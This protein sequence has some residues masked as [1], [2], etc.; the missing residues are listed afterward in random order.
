MPKYSR[1]FRFGRGRKRMRGRGIFDFLA[2]VND[3]LK[4]SKIISSVAGMIPSGL[5][6]G[7]SLGAG[8][9]GYGRRRRRLM[10]GAYSRS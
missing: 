10:G 3:W 6:Q 9:L 2:P 7:I 1:R 8:L 5:G 4:S